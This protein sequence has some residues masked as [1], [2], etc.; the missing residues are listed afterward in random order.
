M[1]DPKGHHSRNAIPML[2]GL[3]LRHLGNSGTHYNSTTQIQRF[4][5]KARRHNSGFEVLLREETIL[6]CHGL[7]NR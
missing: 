5:A 3:Y 2:G 1:N 6:A 4:F 7:Q